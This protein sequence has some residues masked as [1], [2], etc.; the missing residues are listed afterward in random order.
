MN[1][2]II[3]DLV[4]TDSGWYLK[5]LLVLIVILTINLST[6]FLLTTIKKQT[7]KTKNIWDDAIIGSI[8][9]PITFFVWFYG[10]VITIKIFNIEILL[11]QNTGFF[12]GKFISN[13]EQSGII[14]TIALFLLSLTRNLQVAIIRNNEI[15]DREIDHSTY[16]AISKIARLSIFITSGLIILQTFGFS[17]TGVLAFGGIGGIAVGF[18]AKDM[19]ANFF[20]G[21]VIHLDRPFKIGDWIRSPDR[22]IEGVVEKIG[23]RQT[24]IRNF[25]R[26]LV[27]IP[28]S[29]FMNAIVENPS[30]MSHR[31][32]HETIGLR[33]KDLTKIGIIT[34]EVKLMLENHKDI[35]NSQTILV[36]FNA[37]NDSSVDFF[38]RA[39][40]NSVGWEDFHY[41]KEDILLQINKIIENHSA[42]IAYPTRSIITEK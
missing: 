37:F 9:R 4:G 22:E 24:R 38:V 40:T 15:L 20:G 30:R 18:A 41:I 12:S 32:I 10:A 16:D 29:I 6:K 23:W 27:Y 14:I 33:Y 3:F 31:R 19:L 34:N 8:Y 7:D 5:V 25:R 26:N 17:I 42:E 11:N 35:D 28:N 1:L 36:S 39:Y 21:L 13:I 2:N